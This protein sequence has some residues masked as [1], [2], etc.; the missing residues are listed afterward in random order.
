MRRTYISLL[1]FVF[2]LIAIL[3]GGYVWFKSN[4]SSNVKVSFDANNPD[5]LINTPNRIVVID[6]NNGN[7]TK[8]EIYNERFMHTSVY[9]KHTKKL[10]APTYSPE[11]HFAGITEFSNGQA[12]YQKVKDF[13]PMNVVSSNGYLLMDSSLSLTNREGLPVTKLGL[14]DLRSNKFVKEFTV[15]GIVQSMIKV[16]SNAYFPSLCENNQSNIY[17]FDFDTWKL[18]K[19]LK[20]DQPHVPNQ[21]LF[22]KD[23]MI[24][25][26]NDEAAGASSNK[27]KLYY[28]KNGVI[29][30]ELKL[31]QG[32]KEMAI[33]NNKILI[34]YEPYD[35]KSFIEVLKIE[36]SQE[37]EKVK[38]ADNPTNITTWN[39]NLVVIDQH[40]KVYIYNQ[41]L[42]KINELELG[43][44]AQVLNITK[45]N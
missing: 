9:D 12:K 8:R 24:G 22:Y 14:Y 27:N 11:H 40:K 19:V 43:I 25:L 31:K 32:T 34:L 16:G 10:L 29:S 39:Q 6:E 33:L 41:E 4:E 18:D 30:K 21:I 3:A 28:I 42:K 37:A 38:L 5:L 20:M 23:M 36:G 15:N 26:A 2:L 7:L 45:A 17:R 1:F 35:R 13:G 44:D